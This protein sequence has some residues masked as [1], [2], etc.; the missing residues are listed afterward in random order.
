MAHH[1]VQHVL[2]M[3][4]ED[5]PE[6]V[7]RSFAHINNS[8]Y[9]P[10]QGPSELGASG[11]LVDWDRTADLRQISV[12]TLV[13]GG[14]HDTMD[15]AHLREM[16][17]R[18]PQGRYLHCP[19][20]SHLAMYDDQE[21]YFAGLI[22]FV[23]DVD[24]DRLK[25]EIVRLMPLYLTNDDAR[26]VTMTWASFLLRCIRSRPESLCAVGSGRRVG[27]TSTT[28]RSSFT[29]A[30]SR[31]GNEAP[32]MSTFRHHPIQPAWQAPGSAT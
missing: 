21:V 32:S 28:S 11:K 5:W 7:S 22:D 16:A 1:Y 17:S 31:C 19:E 29:S 8:I 15:P 30:V 9:V 2:R 13:I 27:M 23:H 12:P 25:D 10:M 6:P 3:P 26:V 20:G 24:A 18:F 4:A 14:A